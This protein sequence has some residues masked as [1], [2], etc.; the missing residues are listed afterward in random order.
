MDILLLLFLF[1]LVP[2]AYAEESGLDQNMINSK[3]SELETGQ[4]KEKWSHYA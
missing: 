1:S 2:M 4:V 3:L